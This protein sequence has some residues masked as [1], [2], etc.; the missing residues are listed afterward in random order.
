MSP[1]LK[2]SNIVV[3]AVLIQTMVMVFANQIIYMS[4]TMEHVKSFLPFIN[5]L[6]ILI[7]MIVLVFVKEIGKAA[8]REI[9][10]EAMKDNLKQ[11]ESLMKTLQKERHEYNR[12][13]QTIQAMIHLG[14]IENVIQYLDGLSEQNMNV[15][16]IVYL[17]NPVVTV[18]LNAKSRV[19]ES[20]NIKF[21]FAIKCDI[22][23][24]PISSW[25]LSSILGNLL[26]NAFEAVLENEKNN[27]IVGLE[28]KYEQGEYVI[29]IFN[30]GPSISTKMSP[31]IFEPGFTTKD[32]QGRGYGLFLVKNII[33]QYGGRIECLSTQRT[34]FKIHLPERGNKN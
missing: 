30:N 7:T 6:V 23:E 4:D 32:S 16:E 31:K 8:K 27:R 29:Y 25:D 3:I 9:E 10:I 11:T 1:L 18:L 22:T 34:L 13:L 2:A 12:H 5:I 21:D 33:E 28:I 19:A 24:I 17:G 14:E 26:D 20:K 15:H